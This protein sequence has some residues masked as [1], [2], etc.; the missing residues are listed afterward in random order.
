MFTDDNKALYFFLTV[1]AVIV[2]ILTLSKM[3]QSCQM[4]RSNNQV[5]QNINEQKIEAETHNQG[6]QKAYRDHSPQTKELVDEA[7]REANPATKAK[8]KQEAVKEMN[9]S[10]GAK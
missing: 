4:G 7:D 2:G 1:M 6:L 10:V 9:K 5:R 8:L 3:A